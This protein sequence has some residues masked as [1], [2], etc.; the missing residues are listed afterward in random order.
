MVGFIVTLL[1]GTFILVIGVITA[2]GNI[3]LLHSYH[4]NRVSEEDKK[5]L[6]KWAGIGLIIVAVSLIINGALSIIATFLEVDL[7]II[8]ANWIMGVGLV[9][10]L[11]ISL[12]AI[13][14][15]NK[16]IF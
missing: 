3:S 16:G 14:K 15:Y 10:G 13:N 4:R 8:L 11:I 7:L 2:R 12:V 5:P 6:A 1:V 9:I